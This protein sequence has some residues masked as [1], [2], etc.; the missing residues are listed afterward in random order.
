M[1]TAAAGV[2][3]GLAE[4]EL[5]TAVT[6]YFVAQEFAYMAVNRSRLKALAESGDAAAARANRSV[7]IRA[8]AARGIFRTR[9]RAMGA[10]AQRHTVAGHLRVLH[11]RSHRT[12]VRAT[13][14]A[15]VVVPSTGRI[16][17]PIN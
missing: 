3:V 14:D 1:V 13:A 15:A 10:Q 8:L 9:S 11:A 7:G 17:I 6:G 16:W 5:I 4:V 2:L 12:A